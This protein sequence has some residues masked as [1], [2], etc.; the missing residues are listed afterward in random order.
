M[1]EVDFLLI[2]LTF[3]SRAPFFFLHCTKFSLV[4][5]FLSTNRLPSHLQSGYHMISSIY[6]RV[7]PRQTWDRYFE[8]S[9]SPR[10][11]EERCLS[12]SLQQSYVCASDASVLKRSSKRGKQVD[13]QS[14]SSKE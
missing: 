10:Q 12:R 13:M 11:C 6:W 4:F 14:K 9:F 1:K 3:L 5:A 8:E 2:Y 7:P